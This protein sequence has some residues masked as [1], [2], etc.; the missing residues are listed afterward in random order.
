MKKNLFY[1]GTLVLIVAGSIFWSCQK[2]EML[3]NPEEGVMLK[4][5]VVVDCSILPTYD[6]LPNCA[7]NCIGSAPFI[8]G[9][10]SYVR[11][12]GGFTDYNSGL[13]YYQD[14]NYFTS[15]AWNT[16]TQFNIKITAKGFQYEK[17]ALSGGN[18]SA[19]GPTCNPYLFSK[20][21]VI[22]KG[23]PNVEHEFILPSATSVY[24]AVFNLN[25]LFADGWSKCNI[26]EYTVIATYGSDNVW[27]GRPKGSGAESGYYDYST[28]TLFESCSGCEDTFILEEVS[29]CEETDR[30][31]EFKYIA[32]ADGT[33]TIQGGLTSGAANVESEVTVNGEEADP[34]QL[35]AGS[36]HVYNW[37]GEL[38]ECDEVIITI[39]WE[40]TNEEII[41]SWTAKRGTT[42]LVT[43][44][45]ECGEE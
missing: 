4:S 17:T 16:A 43:G 32:G 15:E 3:V 42:T 29:E 41:D 20:V 1:L 13:T 10:N 36:T 28:Y 19:T 5:L 8:Q 37:T 26:I 21:K 45:V 33:V 44:A 11:Q 39:T 25:D 27:L 22:I 31:A 40:A 6:A 18:H 35:K 34:L 9:V 30:Y 7:T 24:T 12:N 2:E 23:T 14:N 38:D